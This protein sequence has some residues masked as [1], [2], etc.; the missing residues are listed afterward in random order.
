M[1]EAI[2]VKAKA[3]IFDKRV[4]GLAKQAVASLA[5]EWMNWS[6]ERAIAPLDVFWL[7]AMTRQPAED[8]PSCS[9]SFTLRT[10][11]SRLF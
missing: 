6:V 7:T 2:N 11:S 10:T 3:A 9:S 5:G 4:F 8:S 1:I